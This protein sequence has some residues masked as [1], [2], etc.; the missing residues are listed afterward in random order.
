VSNSGRLKGVIEAVARANGWSWR[1]ELVFDPDKVLVAA[2]D[3]LVVTADSVILDGCG[4]WLSLARAVVSE[5]PGAW[6]VDLSGT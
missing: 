3:E 5:C 1:V 2:R 6:V 4:A